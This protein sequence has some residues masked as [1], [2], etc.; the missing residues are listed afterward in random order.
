MVVGF[1][2]YGP[3]R[4]IFFLYDVRY[5]PKFWGIFAYG[6][7]VVLAPFVRNAILSSVHYLCAFA[8]THF[9]YMWG[10]VFRLFFF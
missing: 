3:F 10:F 4:I 8:T 2:V 7:P 1:K 5:R 6:N 9:I